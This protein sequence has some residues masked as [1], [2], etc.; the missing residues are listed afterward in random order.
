MESS[1]QFEFHFFKNI[2]EETYADFQEANPFCLFWSIDRILYLIHGNKLCSII[3]YDLNNDKRI[4]E[5]KKAHS[6]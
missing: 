1:E 6:N 3:S 5:I 2:T 4:N